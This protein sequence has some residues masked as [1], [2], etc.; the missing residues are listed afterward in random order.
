MGIARA[1][2]ALAA[3]AIAG[4]VM[5]FAAG[6]AVAATATTASSAPQATV[7]PGSL[8]FKVQVNEFNQS[9]IDSNPQTVT[10]TNTGTAPLSISAAKIVNSAGGFVIGNRCVSILVNGS[11]TT[12]CATP[13][14][15][16]D[17]CSGTTLA[18]GGSCG[19]SVEYEDAA[20]FPSASGSLE[21]VSNSPTSPNVVSLS[22]TS[23]FISSPLVSA[24]AV[25]GG[26]PGMISDGQNANPN[27]GGGIELGGCWA[28]VGP[29]GPGAAANSTWGAVGPVTID[30]DVTLF[31]TS[32]NDELWVSPSIGQNPLFQNNTIYAT[33]SNAQY[34]VMVAPP[35]TV[36][37]TGASRD[38]VRL[39]EPAP[40]ID[41][42]ML[43]ITTNL[44]CLPCEESTWAVAGPNTE[45]LGVVDLGA[46]PYVCSHPPATG[47]QA[48]LSFTADAPPD[49]I[50]GLPITGGEI[51]FGGP[52]ITTLQPGNFCGV[53]TA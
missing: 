4:A 31:P 14:A 40:A 34:V 27:T 22:A 25:P 41:T 43:T 32:A 17:T 10:L 26:C 45:R 9:T 35:A 21:I 18:V 20:Q 1:R 48:P 51:V 36:G 5:A 15:P 38:H 11:F 52:P 24:G 46:N 3:A 28:S 37:A 16:L 39:E 53:L 42:H 50:H 7:T 23:T 13:T 44:P 30:G 12:P 19:V 29:G 47:C 33:P 8:S 6:S 49:V 2:A